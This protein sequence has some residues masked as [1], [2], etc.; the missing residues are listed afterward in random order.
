M[1][2]LQ[3]IYSSLSTTAIILTEAVD[4]AAKDQGI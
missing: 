3:R 1:L 4:Q 2:E